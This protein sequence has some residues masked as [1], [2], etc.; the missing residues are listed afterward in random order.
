MRFLTQPQSFRNANRNA[1]LLIFIPGMDGTGELFKYQ[2]SGL[3][4]SFDIRGIV[5]PENDLST[6][7]ELV[8]KASA[9]IRQELKS[10]AHRPVYLC[11]ESFGG[12]LALQVA[13]ASPDLCQGLILINSA[14]AFARQTW[15]HW[16]SNIVQRMSKPLYELAALS[17]MPLLIA[18]DR[19]PA[20]NRQAL[21]K[22]M[23]S[24]SPQSAAWR[25]SLLSHF[26]LEALPLKQLHQPVLVITGA[27]DLLLPSSAEADRLV[28]ALPNA[29][30]VELPNSG[31]ACLLESEV[32]LAEILK[33][34]KFIKFPELQ[35]L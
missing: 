16:I 15:L 28:R 26:K 25:I 29:K 22:A 13:I 30:K 3:E 9:L 35:V 32:S 18:N 23:Q 14:S 17:I 1:P 2:A 7:P 4:N 33:N 31:H 34:E 6:W 20:S 11:G 12:C 19:V 24:V 27:A 8:E 10:T 5:L 21:L